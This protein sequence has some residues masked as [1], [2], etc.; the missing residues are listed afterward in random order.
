M[1]VYKLSEVGETT[2][3]AAGVPLKYGGLVSNVLQAGWLTV[4]TI[5]PEKEKVKQHQD[6]LSHRS[7][8]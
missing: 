6:G 3:E 8:H 4:S 2:V 1:L 7:G 5:L